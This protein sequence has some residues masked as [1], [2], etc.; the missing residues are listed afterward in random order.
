MLDGNQV[1]TLV[2]VHDSVRRAF[3]ALLTT[4]DVFASLAQLVG[5][6]DENDLAETLFR[7][8]RTTLAAERGI[9]F[10]EAGGPAGSLLPIDLVAVDLPILTSSGEQETLVRYVL[11]RGERVL[12]PRTTL[13]EGP[14][15]L[16]VAGPMGNGKT[17]MSKLLA[18]AYRAS[19]LNGASDLGELATAA[20]EGIEARLKELGL[21]G[22]PHHRRWP[23]RIDLAAFAED[24][25]QSERTL[26]RYIADVISRRTV[27]TVNA[28][29]MDTW[30]RR[31]PW[32]LVLDG[33]D[34]V[35]EPRTRRSIIDRVLELVEDADANN[36][37]LF[38]VLTTRPVGYTEDIAPTLFERVDLAPL[39]IDQALAYGKNVARVRLGKD[40]E[41]VPR[42]DRGLERA[43]ASENTRE[44]MVTP[45]QVLILTIIIEAA[46]PLPPDRFALFWGYYDTV[47][48]RER[49][50]PGSLKEILDAHL[51]NITILHER[52]GY[53]LHVRA[54]L[55]DHA[56]ATMSSEE[57]RDVIAAVLVD[58]GHDPDGADADL[59]EDIRKACLQRLLLIRAHN[60]GV[61]FDVRALQELMAG[62]HLTTGP[63]D[64]VEARLRQL[65]AHPHWR[66]PW[67]FAAGRVF[68]ETQPHRRDQIVEIVKAID[69]DASWRLGRVSPVGPGLALD[70]AVDGGARKH[71]RV[72]K[73]L[74]ANA[75]E[76][77][78]GPAPK[79]AR[80]TTRLL[81]RAAGASQEARSMVAAALR[82]A[83]GGDP[84]TRLIAE[85][86]QTMIPDTAGEL[87]ASDDVRMLA[88]VKS[89]G[90]TGRQDAPNPLV[91]W[92]GVRESASQ[93]Q[94][95]GAVGGAA[96][97]AAVEGAYLLGLASVAGLHAVEEWEAFAGTSA[98]SSHPELADA[99]FELDLRGPILIA[100][101][102]PEAAK[103]LEGFLLDLRF[104]DP[105]AAALLRDWVLAVRTSVAW[106]QDPDPTT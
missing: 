54:Q 64:R 99:H 89:A 55:S 39:P 71:P 20:S 51:P 1:D 79:D 2:S 83:L 69:D 94:A 43:A 49:V 102:D 86:L 57:L 46:G 77:F 19:L 48:K 31:W 105:Q 92:Q 12:R 50:K 67:I 98:Q 16:V 100:L 56:T 17:T 91:W 33:L 25:G 61:G 28:A 27:R 68:A 106:E 21:H 84:G 32:F 63:D 6:V 95:A 9:T 3:N 44:L 103:L 78:D 13:H 104:Q 37:D 22:L 60:E 59:V 30:M 96:A 47:S 10:D 76:I 24:E 97:A 72:R 5:F 81:L 66:V 34:E 41:A 75:L 14:R 62:R 73:P 23:M 58:D 11:N 15:H 65:A 80:A 35:T 29:H 7:H 70:L 90:V 36:L 93:V 87:S 42:V 74:L 88:S 26:L 18:Q 4:G 40:H 38:V 45:L 52:V 8:A 85:H 53:E 101:D 82:K